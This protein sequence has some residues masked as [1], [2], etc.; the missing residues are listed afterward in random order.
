[1]N[2]QFPYQNDGTES[3][4]PLQA[5]A[6]QARVLMDV[7][8]KAM[9]DLD[10]R[11]RIQAE[12]LVEIKRKANTNLRFRL[13][14]QRN[15]FNRV[16][17]KV[18]LTLENRLTE[19]QVLLNLVANK[20][21]G[22]GESYANN[23]GMENQTD[24]ESLQ[25]S[26]GTP[27]QTGTQT[28][29]GIRNGDVQGEIT[30]PLGQES[31]FPSATLP[32]SS[33]LGAIPR[34]SCPPCDQI[35]PSCPEPVVLTGGGTITYSFSNNT[36]I[37]SNIS[38]ST[39]ELQIYPADGGPPVTIP[40]LVPAENAEQM[41]PGGQVAIIINGTPGQT[42]VSG[43]SFES[44]VTSGSGQIGGNQGGPEHGGPG[45]PGGLVQSGPFLSTP[46]TAASSGGIAAGTVQTTGND[47]TL[48]GGNQGSEGMLQGG[49]WFAGVSGTLP[50]VSQSQ[51]TQPG[52]GITHDNYQGA[53]FG[54]T[55]PGTTPGGPNVGTPIGG[56]GATQTLTPSQPGQGRQCVIVWGVP[57]TPQNAGGV[58]PLLSPASLPPTH[59]EIPVSEIEI[60]S[61][62]FDEED[63]WAWLAELL[64]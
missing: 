20:I 32:V 2:Y 60:E 55:N 15:R 16:F 54:A 19:Q 41:P 12:A 1:M 39:G 21:P 33:G 50:S 40:F 4:D 47:G 43:G 28:G 18:A 37:T 46:G 42:I 31:S 38:L 48:V 25:G 36:V 3:S 45:F 11:L 23:N 35:R 57:C 24:G 44:V 49:N 56:N 53:G 51:G 17:E 62:P 26:N 29:E 7:I 8:G 10:V 63:E 9:D 61:P 64:Q 58:V 22:V 5:T 34:P 14:T 6:A 30:S 59:E 13:T 52:S 27:G